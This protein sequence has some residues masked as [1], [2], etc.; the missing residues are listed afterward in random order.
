MKEENKLTF[1]NII[2]FV[3]NNID[4]TNTHRLPA[5]GKNAIAA[6]YDYDFKIMQ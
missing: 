3:Q 1:C 6:Q 5:T 2:K 4:F